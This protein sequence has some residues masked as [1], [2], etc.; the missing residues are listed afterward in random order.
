M[1]NNNNY[2]N[3]NHNYNKI[4]KSDWLSTALIS[5]LIGQ[6]NRTV[7]AITYALKWFSFSLLAKNISKF[8]MFWLRKEPNIPQ[9]LLNLWI[10]GNRTSC[11][12]IRSVIVLVIEQIGLPLRGCPVLL[13]TRL[14]TDRI[15]LHS[16]LLPLLLLPLLLLLLLLL[17]LPDNNTWLWQEIISGKHK[18]DNEFEGTSCK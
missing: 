2:Y 16:V 5:A 12:P 3:H 18:T 8:L 6:L 4:L 15:R 17:L 10:I 14:T 1:I 11:R 7:R 13:I 9:I